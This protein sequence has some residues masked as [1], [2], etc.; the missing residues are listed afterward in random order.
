MD[1]HTPIYLQVVETIKESIIRGELVEG[2]M[3][4][5]VRKYTT[6]LGYSLQTVFNA[7]RV[8]ILQDVLKKRRGVGLFVVAGAK[9]RL[10]AEGIE[11][12]NKTEIPE[13]V[14]RAKLLEITTADI[15]K[16]VDK[17]W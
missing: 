12:L 9:A 2:N 16:I 7:I 15:T 10:L 5:S 3:I 17:L 6:D 4:P 11:K 14:R 13:L 8:L 1:A